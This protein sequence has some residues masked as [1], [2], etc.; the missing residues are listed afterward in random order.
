MQLWSGGLI[1]A[2]YLWQGILS[3]AGKHVLELGCGCIALP[4]IV[5]AHV[6]APVVIASDML[7]EA[8]ESALEHA[9]PHGVR[10]ESMHWAEQP[11]REA[12]G[13]CLADIVLWAEA[14]YTELG[15]EHLAHAVKANLSPSGM[16]VAVVPAQD[17]AG[18]DVFE[19]KMNLGG[20]FRTTD[21][22]IPDIVARNVLRRFAG[23]I[24]DEDV[25]AGCR[26]ITWQWEDLYG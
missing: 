9:G 20:F 8:V 13:R 26:L 18:M 2:E 11:D 5:A 19:Q 15:A 16:C 21:A 17:R 22:Q 23:A 3:V 14:V 10:V 4:S 1:L 12:K 6:G 24:S 25:V 7:T